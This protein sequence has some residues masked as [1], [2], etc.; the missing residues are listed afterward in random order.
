MCIR[1]RIRPPEGSAPEYEEGYGG[2]QNIYKPVAPGHMG[3]EDTYRTY[4]NPH[5]GE[6]EY[7]QPSETPT[8]INR[9][10]GMVRTPEEIDQQWTEAGMTRIPRP[11]QTPE[12]LAE[13]QRRGLQP[14]IVD[15]S[16]SFQGS[17]WDKTLGGGIFRSNAYDQA[18]DTEQGYTRVRDWGQDPEGNRILPHPRSGMEYW[19][20]E[21]S[22]TPSWY[23]EQR[24]NVNRRQVEKDVEEAGKFRFKDMLPGWLGG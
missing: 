21:G 2:Y 14:T 23:H 18:P 15:P 22:E 1:D 6:I 9:E 3:R 5:T 12:Q 13:I 10:T 16:P 7:A 4:T 17:K 24:K 8:W 11:A 19:Y 20:P